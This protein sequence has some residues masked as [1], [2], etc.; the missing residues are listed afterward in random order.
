LLPGSTEDDPFGK[1]ILRFSSSEFRNFLT[2]AAWLAQINV[3]EEGYSEKAAVRR[4][5]FYFAPR[6]QM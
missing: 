4:K 5:F 6:G 1:L 2:A 3:D